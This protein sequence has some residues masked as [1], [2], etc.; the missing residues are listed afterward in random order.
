M[1][2][3]KLFSLLLIPVLCLICVY[4]TFGSSKT[5]SIHILKHSHNS[6]SALNLNVNF[7]RFNWIA[8]LLPSI[9]ADNFF[10]IQNNENTT[11]LDFFNI[12]REEFCRNDSSHCITGT[13]CS[14]KTEVDFRI[15]PIV[16]DRA[17]SL[18]RCLQTLYDLDTMGDRI[19]VNIWIDR[20]TSGEINMNTYNVAME[21]ALTW[22]KGYACVHN[23]TRNAYITGQW[24]DTWRPAPS[25]N[26]LGII[27]ED[28]ITI[29]PLAYRWLRTVHRQYGSWTNISGYSLQM[30]NVNFFAGGSR[31]MFGPSSDN[32]F[33][34]PVLGTWGFAP[35]PGSWR[36]FQDWYH[37]VRVPNSILK[38][39]VPGIVPTGWYQMFEGQ[40]RQ[41]SMWEMWHIYFAY[42][43]KLWCVY[44]NLIQFSGRQDVILSNN[45]M[46]R[47]LHF[48][49]DGAQVVSPNLLK[50]WDEK[51]KN[52]PSRPVMYSYD[53]NNLNV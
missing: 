30:E 37:S 44:S 49:G 6:L 50:T 45:R 39:Y 8:N 35:H 15:I 40:G 13:P 34:Y 46:E 21:F 51:F 4:F 53:G 9:T 1:Q 16:F 22:K 12:K 23:Q 3:L 38:P 47:G 28:D 41:E 14:Y 2:N 43:K 17:D 29:S 10:D 27:I 48:H 25:G 31:P 26:E 7:S 24:V 18:K 52:F 36:E 33:M 32:V 5:T 42:I 19:V 20:S 11:T